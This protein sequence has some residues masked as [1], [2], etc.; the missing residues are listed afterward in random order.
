[1]FDT[2]NQLLVGPSLAYVHSH[3]HAIRSFLGLFTAFDPAS[4]YLKL[5][6]HELDDDFE[7]VLVREAPAGLHFFGWAGLS[8][9]GTRIAL[10]PPRGVGTLGRQFFIFAVRVDISEV[11]FYL[12]TNC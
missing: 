12:D 4:Q 10:V 1:M 6:V 8:G 11:F 3:R 9:A 5:V 2:F 7:Q